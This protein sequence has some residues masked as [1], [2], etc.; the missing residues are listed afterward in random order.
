[1]AETLD[2]EEQFLAAMQVVEQQ[3]A[4]QAAQLSAI[5]DDTV[6]GGVLRSSLMDSEKAIILEG[7]EVDPRNNSPVVRIGNLAARLGNDDGAVYVDVPYRGEDGTEHEDTFRVWTTGDGGIPKA[8]VILDI[9]DREAQY[10]FPTSEEA[11][12]AAG[13]RLTRDTQGVAVTS[14]DPHYERLVGGLI[15]PTDQVE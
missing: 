5:Q 6:R 12:A 2:R 1:M 10:T 11:E 14:G 4:E 13:Q 3:L 7:I 15:T 9:V 8:A